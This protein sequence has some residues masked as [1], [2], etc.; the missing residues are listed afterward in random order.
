VTISFDPCLFEI[1]L[2]F[3]YSLTP[4]KPICPKK[5]RRFSSLLRHPTFMDYT[6]PH[7]GTVT[8]L[9]LLVNKLKSS[10]FVVLSLICRAPGESLQITNL[11][12]DVFQTWWNRHQDSNFRIQFCRTRFWISMPSNL[13]DGTASAIALHIYTKVQSMCS[14]GDAV[15]DIHSG[16]TS[17][18]WSSDL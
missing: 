9:T 11:P 5:I 8:Q 6:F 15:V 12:P 4:Q 3:H 16:C 13:H 14:A 18:A 17:P 2:I 10:T 1:N 7:H